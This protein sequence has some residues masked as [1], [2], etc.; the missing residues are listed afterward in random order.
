MLNNQNE[1][2]VLFCFSKGWVEVGRLRSW[3]SFTWLQVV[4]SKSV[5]LRSR[6]VIDPRLE[7]LGKFS[8]NFRVSS[9]SSLPIWSLLEFLCS[10]SIL[11]PLILPSSDL[12][13]TILCFPSNPFRWRL[14]PKRPQAYALTG[15]VI[16]DGSRTSLFFDERS[17]EDF[18][19]FNFSNLWRWFFELFFMRKLL[20]QSWL[21]FVIVLEFRF[22]PFNFV[23]DWLGLGDRAL[24]QFWHESAGA[25]SLF[26]FIF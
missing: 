26:S 1:H 4:E 25:G 21:P 8:F 15:I 19:D 12:P 16:L 17:L 11:V 10:A 5:G 2:F 9:I 22:L 18:V 24:I 7:F 20:F 6:N 23:R 3:K 14:H 13:T